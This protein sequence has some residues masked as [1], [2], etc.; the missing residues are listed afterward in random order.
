MTKQSHMCLDCVASLAMTGK[1]LASNGKYAR[2]D[3]KRHNTSLR[4]T[5]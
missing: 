1:V 2:D 5:K 3:N 4:E